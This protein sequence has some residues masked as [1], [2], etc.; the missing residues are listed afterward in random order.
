[1]WYSV[2]TSHIFLASSDWL[3]NRK[4]TRDA[5]SKDPTRDTTPEDL[6]RDTTTKDLARETTT[7][8]L[9]V[10]QQPKILRVKQQAKVLR[11]KQ[12]PNILRV[13]QQAKILHVKQQAKILRVKQQPKIL[14]VMQ[15]PNII[16]FLCLPCKFFSGLATRTEKTKRFELYFA[17]ANRNTQETRDHKSSTAQIYLTPSR[18]ARHA[19]GDAAT[20]TNNWR[21]WKSPK[22]SFCIVQ[23][24]NAQQAKNTMCPRSVMKRF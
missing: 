15:K 13:K 17:S 4:L 6:V 16:C 11:L 8:I 24:N 1:M 14:R 2:T 3:H 19:L 22:F 10:K 20:F 9:H 23:T 7:K 12:Q 5:T 18:L 21:G